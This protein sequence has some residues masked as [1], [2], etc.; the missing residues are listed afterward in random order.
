MWSHGTVEVNF[1]AAYRKNEESSC[2][3]ILL[4]DSRGRVIASKITFHENIPSPFTAKAVTCAMALKMYL[5]LNI[6]SLE[7]EGD[8]LTVI[9]KQAE[10]RLIDLK[11]R[12]ILKI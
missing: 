11:S 7:V 12:Y 3:G 5:D 6:K 2:S 9:K 1:D 8:S 4:R 10:M